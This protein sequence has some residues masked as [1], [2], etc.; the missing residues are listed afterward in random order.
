M[1]AS[2]APGITWNL[3]DT[4]SLLSRNLLATHLWSLSHLDLFAPVC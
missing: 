4:Q 3:E 1:A 2:L